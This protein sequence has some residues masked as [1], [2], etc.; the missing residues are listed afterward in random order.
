MSDIVHTDHEILIDQLFRRSCEV[1]G[2]PHFEWRPLRRRVRGRGRSRSIALG[3]TKIG[4]NLITLDLY[5]PRTMV[6]RKIDAILRVVC[7]ELAHHQAPPKIYR[8]WF[9]V[10]RR[11]HHPEFWMQCKQNIISLQQDDI[12]KVYFTES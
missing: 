5:T 3:Y 7:H 10:V 2:M 8:S 9:R 1:L 11:I 4:T 6:P 12:L